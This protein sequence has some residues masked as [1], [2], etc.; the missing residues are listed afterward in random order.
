[1]KHNFQREARRIAR[2][3]VQRSLSCARLAER[4]AHRERLAFAH[5]GAP[6]L[7][8]STNP[9]VILEYSARLTADTI[10]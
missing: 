9:A 3:A 6:R 5:V 7:M 10:K 1:V 2:R 8:S 4:R